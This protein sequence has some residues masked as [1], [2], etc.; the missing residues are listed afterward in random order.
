MYS[1]NS[2]IGQ[3]RRMGAVVN[4]VAVKNLVL[5]QR[6]GRGEIFGVESKGLPKGV[7]SKPPGSEPHSGIF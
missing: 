5:P 4:F 2:Q 7:L 6:S 3:A 1:M